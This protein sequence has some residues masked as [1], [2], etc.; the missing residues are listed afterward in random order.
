[1]P[2]SS[3]TLG[4]ISRYQQIRSRQIP[5]E[6]LPHLRSH[7][8]SLHSLECLM[9]VGE[10]DV[11]PQQTDQREVAQLEVELRLAKLVRHVVRVL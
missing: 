8:Q 3:H 4:P 7:L 9:V 11:R 5:A 2:H 1:M 6:S 10:K